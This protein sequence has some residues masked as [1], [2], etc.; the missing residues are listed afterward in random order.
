MIGTSRRNILLGVCLLMLAGLA[1]RLAWMQIIQADEYREK[2][3]RVYYH[4][5][6]L[7]EELRYRLV[8]PAALFIIIPNGIDTDRFR[9]DPEARARLRQALGIAREANVVVHVARV[10]PM[11][12]HATLL[13]AMER[14]PNAT[15]LLVGKGTER[16]AAPP[17]VLGLGERIWTRLGAQFARKP[18]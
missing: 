3:M 8:N 2:G 17:R 15:L 9:P 11:K 5:M 1:G 7:L 13:S 10:D 12:D 14:V 18:A 4:E 16:L 6:G